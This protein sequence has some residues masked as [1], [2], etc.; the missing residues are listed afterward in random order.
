VLQ[1]S[2]SDPA[3]PAAR[4]ACATASV[5]NIVDSLAPTTGL[6]ASGAKKALQELGDSEQIDFKAYGK[7]TFYLSKQS[8]YTVPPEEE[9]KKEEAEIRAAKEQLDQLREEHKQLKRAVDTASARQTDA[10]LQAEL[11]A[12]RVETAAMEEKLRA[13]KTGACKLTVKDVQA[14][15]DTARTRLSEW[16]TRKRATREIVERIAEGSG[17]RPRDIFTDMGCE[18]VIFAAVS[19]T[20]SQNLQCLT[21][22]CRHA[23]S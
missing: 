4:D 10:E 13:S 2:A 3:R 23:G 22:A 5:T 21:S 14:L 20:S 1:P 11:A 7:Q 16:K 19:L 17:K 15:E 9:I 12:L 18:E 6:N 8:Q